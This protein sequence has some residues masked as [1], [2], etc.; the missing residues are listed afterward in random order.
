MRGYAPSPTNSRS[1]KETTLADCCKVYKS[2]TKTGKE[3]ISHQIPGSCSPCWCS[4]NNRRRRVGPYDGALPPQRPPSPCGPTGHRDASPAVAGRAVA[5]LSSDILR[6]AGGPG[7]SRPPPAVA[8]YEGMM[9]STTIAPPL[10]APLDSRTKRRY[11]RARFS[12]F[13]HL[14]SPPSFW[15]PRRW[16]RRRAPAEYPT[17]S[18]SR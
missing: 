6:L 17:I 11:R 7:T 5:L 9:G 12:S 3:G 4:G 18:M 13:R 15:P 14:P 8:D 2:I 16:R 10:V 1:S